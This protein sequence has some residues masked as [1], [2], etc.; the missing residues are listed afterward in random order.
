MYT[1]EKIDINLHVAS[2]EDTFVWYK[3]VLD[4]DSSCD[5]RDEQGR[6]LF[7]DVHYT[8]DEPLVGFNLHREANPGLPVGFHPLIK[9]TNIAALYEHVQQ[10][11]VEIVAEL[12]TQHWG[13]NFQMKDCNGFVLEFWEAI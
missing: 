1:L 8:Y 6:C 11:K 5:L 12:A 3:T 10:H 9:T 4:W 2:I 7:G 13:R